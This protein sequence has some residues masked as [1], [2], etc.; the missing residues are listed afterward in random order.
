MTFDVKKVVSEVALCTV[1]TSLA[2]YGL[3]QIYPAPSGTFLV[4][5]GTVSACSGVIL[6]RLDHEAATQLSRDFENN[7]AKFYHLY[8]AVVLIAQTL[9]VILF[10]SA[11]QRMGFQVPG[12]IQTF[13]YLGLA[14]RV[15]TLTKCAA[16]F[17]YLHH[18]PEEK[19]L[20]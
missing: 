1:S 13:G 9:L 12:L 7:N 18:Y 6:S 4:V 11:A 10:R 16:E 8:G 5:I 2:C 14:G 17:I 3:H 20:F 15:F 19:K